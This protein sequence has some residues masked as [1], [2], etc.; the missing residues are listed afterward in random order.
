ML[1]SIPENSLAVAKLNWNVML[2]VTYN[3][4]KCSRTL[5]CKINGVV[6]MVNSITRMK[7]FVIPVIKIAVEW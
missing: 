2:K 5:G 7:W 4:F 1:I 6:S 3:H